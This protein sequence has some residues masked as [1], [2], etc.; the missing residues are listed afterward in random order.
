MRFRFLSHAAVS[1][2]LNDRKG[3]TDLVAFKRDLINFGYHLQATASIDF[4]SRCEKVS[5]LYEF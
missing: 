5:D 3:L 2:F 1:K 4:S